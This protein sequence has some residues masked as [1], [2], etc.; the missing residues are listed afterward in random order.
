LPTIQ[1]IVAS[2]TARLPGSRQ[3]LVTAAADLCD[4]L[5]EAYA[6]IPEQLVTSC[7]DIVE[8]PALI[9]AGSRERRQQQLLMRWKVQFQEAGSAIGK[10]GLVVNPDLSSM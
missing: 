10:V 1:L 2:L 8:D 4:M 3:D 6:Q 7:V 9:R 5:A